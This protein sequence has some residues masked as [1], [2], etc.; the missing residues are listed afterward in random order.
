MRGFFSIFILES[1]FLAKNRI[2][3]IDNLKMKAY[4][5]VVF[6]KFLFIECQEKLTDIFYIQND[7]IV[8]SNFH[9][10]SI[11]L[12]TSNT[13]VRCLS[14]CSILVT[15]QSIMFSNKDEVCFIYSQAPI[16]QTDTLFKPDFTI[17]IKKK[18]NFLNHFCIKSIVL[19]FIFEALNKKLSISARLK[20]EFNQNEIVYSLFNLKNQIL[21]TG[22]IGSTINMRNIENG[23]IINKLNGHTSS[24]YDFK[25]LKDTNKIASVSFDFTV[26][27]WDLTTGATYLTF[28]G[29]TNSVRC[30]ELLNDGSLATGGVDKTLL[31]WNPYTGSIFKRIRENTD[32][33][34]SIQVLYNG[35]V[36]TGSEDGYV[37]IFNTSTGIQILETKISAKRISDF[38]V[39]P[40][41]LLICSSFDSIIR[42]LNI[43]TGNIA[44]QLEGHEGGIF[45]LK[46][47]S[48]GLLVSGSID[49][50]FKIWNLYDR[51][52]LTSIPEGDTVR[53]LEELPMGCFA[54]GSYSGAIKF[55]TLEINYL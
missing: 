52:L 51:A 11:I 34:Q 53:S 40:N 14:S 1:Y 50:T 48:N 38:V 16:A 43:Y 7:I 23:Q 17:Y 5:V 6:L 20:N 9:S 33:I 32:S 2:F 39:S 12:E 35:N 22:L 15:C 31:I 26:R 27:V 46:Y 13:L 28:T 55:W 21:V 18:V 47:L 24:V 36:A 30:I 10:N 42:I 41:G 45:A 29:H 25:F 3:L 19:I 4:F 8:S 54:T 49:R 37:R 44:Y